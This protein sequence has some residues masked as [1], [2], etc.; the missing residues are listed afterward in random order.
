MIWAN[1]RPNGLFFTGHYNQWTRGPK[2]PG[3]GTWGPGT[4]DPGPGTQGPEDPGTQGYLQLLQ[5]TEMQLQANV[6]A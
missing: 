3:P 1:V 5:E 6:K 2:D 4:G